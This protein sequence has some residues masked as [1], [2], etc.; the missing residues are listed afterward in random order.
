VGFVTVAQKDL[1]RS[2]AA[3]A[4]NKAKYGELRTTFDYRGA[5]A[6]FTLPGIPDSGR[7]CQQ[8]DRMCSG[9]EERGVGRLPS[10][11]GTEESSVTPHVTLI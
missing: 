10:V 3:P 6:R 5:D 9:A 8:L 4:Q 2:K 7:P 11:C 1:W